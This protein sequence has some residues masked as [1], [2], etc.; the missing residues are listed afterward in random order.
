MTFQFHENR[1][2][3]WERRQLDRS[4]CPKWTWEN[5]QS[6]SQW[7]LVSTGVRW[8]FHKLCSNFEVK[9]ANQNR[10]SK[11]DCGNS[12]SGQHQ[13]AH[14]VIHSFKRQRIIGWDNGR[15]SRDS[16]WGNHVT[17]WWAS[18]WKGL[19]LDVQTLKLYHQAILSLQ[20]KR[21]EIINTVSNYA[22]SVLIFI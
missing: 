12:G 11:S 6:H 21:P 7:F 2:V 16:R 4:L 5:I 10:V 1:C 13:R 19:S 20:Q 17:P 18:L 14:R 3:C 22:H 15:G 9:M 8:R